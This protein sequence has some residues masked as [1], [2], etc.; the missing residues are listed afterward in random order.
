M[1]TTFDRIDT[2]DFFEL[3]VDEKIAPGYYAIVKEPIC[4]RQIGDKLNKHQYLTA[5]DF[6]VC[7]DV[8]RQLRD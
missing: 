7:S 2:N 1:L 8:S 3:P 5:A 4:L 6:K